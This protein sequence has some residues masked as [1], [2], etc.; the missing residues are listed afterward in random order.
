MCVNSRTLPT[1]LCRKDMVSCRTHSN[2]LISFYW[3]H[4][5]SPYFSIFLLLFIFFVSLNLCLLSLKTRVVHLPS[6]S[7]EQQASQLPAAKHS[8]ESSFTALPT[9]PSRSNC[10]CLRVCMFYLSTKQSCLLV[11]ICLCWCVL[12][13]HQT[14][15]FV[16]VYLLV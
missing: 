14:G 8:S 2:G 5:I 12:A 1:V 4:S 16:S 13:F 7:H 3:F 9:T 6:S 15:L 11:C 10:V